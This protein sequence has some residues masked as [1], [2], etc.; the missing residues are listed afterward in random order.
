MACSDTSYVRIMFL[1]GN[2]RYTYYPFMHI[3][4]D[5]QPPGIVEEARRRREQY[6][7]YI[8]GRAA[9]FIENPATQRRIEQLIDLRVEAEVIRPVAERAKCG[10]A[11]VERVITP[12][13]PPMSDIMAVVG[14]LLG[15]RRAREVAWPRQVAALLARELR[16]DLG[17]PAIG[18]AF[19][20]RDH[21][22]MLHTRKAA[23]A[24]I[25]DAASNC[26]WIYWQAKALLAPEDR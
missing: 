11:E 17:S 24:R 5:N 14:E 4:A 10:L 8:E 6:A 21:T 19:G 1:T 15:P 23:G 13:G 22:T 25:A 26:A 3:S 12:E 18:R 16:P 20:G 7:R 2:I 9:V